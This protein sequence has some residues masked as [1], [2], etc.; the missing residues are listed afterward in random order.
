MKQ[1][2]TLVLV[3]TIVLGFAQKSKD[4][5]ESKKATISSS[6]KT[7]KSI[8]ASTLLYE[9]FENTTFPPAGW[10]KI[11][12]ASSANHWQQAFDADYS[13]S[14]MAR[15]LYQ[16]VNQDEWLITP[17]ISIPTNM[18]ILFFDWSMF[19]DWMVDPD[20][21]GD[22]NVKVSTDGGT[23]WTLLW[24]EDNQTMVQNSGVVFPWETYT[25]YTSKIDLSAYSGQDVKIAFQYVAN[26]AARVMI[27]NITINELDPYDA[28]VLSTDLPFFTTLGSSLTLAGDLRNYGSAEINTLDL[29][30]TVNGGSVNTQNLVGLTIDNLSN[31]TYSHSIT[32]T[33]SETG[34]YTFKIWTENINSNA[35]AN[36]TNDTITHVIYVADQLAQRFGIFESFTST[37]C[38]PC[39]SVNPDLDA[40]LASNTDKIV[41]IKYHQNFPSV[42]DPMYIFNTNANDYRFDYYSG[43]FVPYGVLGTDFAD[44]SGYVDQAMIDGEYAKPSPFTINGTYEIIGETININGE[45]TSLVEYASSNL[46]YHVVVIEDYVHYA[47]APTPSADNGERDFY[48]VM[49]KM[50]PDYNG[51]AMLPQTVNQVTTFSES[52]TFQSNSATYWNGSA[53]STVTINEPNLTDMAQMKAVV[54]VQDNNTKEIHQAGLLDYYTGKESINSDISVNVYPNPSTGII[55]ISNAE[56]TKITVYNILGEQILSA[57]SLYNTKSLNLSTFENGTYII[58]IEKGNKLSTKKIVLTK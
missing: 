18:T 55:T 39:A 45:I 21:N 23:N 17:T 22:L 7:L 29:N 50:L 57:N 9:D 25:W 54:F 3:F 5:L 48:Q 13:T 16:A 30:W 49:R 1:I 38:S 43:G 33:P 51:N 32:W 2:F 53:Y 26:D 8:N 42:G 4:E 12:G 20:D 19:F 31:Y 28:G 58:Q 24:V 35:D 10:S 27:D 15:V 46:V 56:N 47:T 40:L 14:G 6:Y 11:D 36:N 44:N 34:T 52:Y 37:T 41:A